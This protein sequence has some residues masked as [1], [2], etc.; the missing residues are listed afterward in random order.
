M[1]W[2][3]SQ[4]HCYKIAVTLFLMRPIGGHTTQTWRM[5]ARYAWRYERIV[6]LMCQEQP[7]SLET[8]MLPVP[9]VEI[10]SSFGEAAS[11]VL[12]RCCCSRFL[13]TFFQLTY[14]RIQFLHSGSFSI[15]VNLGWCFR[16]V[17]C[18]EGDPPRTVHSANPASHRS[19]ASCDKVYSM[20]LVSTCPCPKG[21]VHVCVFEVEPSSIR[22]FAT[23]VAI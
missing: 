6:I 12:P 14:F 2:C 22:S 1:C 16:W 13:N 8:A 3:D 9:T 4:L 20:E 10:G 11:K 7:K 21:A 18:R 15:R 19:E 17:R 23:F 5:F